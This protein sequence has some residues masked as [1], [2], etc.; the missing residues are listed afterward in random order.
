M[1]VGTCQSGTA[2]VIKLLAFWSADTR[3]YWQTGHQY[4]MTHVSVHNLGC[5]HQRRCMQ[6]ILV[7][8]CKHTTRV[9]KWE[10]QL[11]VKSAEEVYGMIIFKRF[12]RLFLTS[13]VIADRKQNKSLSD[14][15][16]TS[17]HI[18]LPL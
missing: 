15:V 4:T 14:S 1:V 18:V 3:R 6:P 17:Q 16:H 5:V 2:A 12:V 10:N 11:N 13:S 9:I 7:V 8:R